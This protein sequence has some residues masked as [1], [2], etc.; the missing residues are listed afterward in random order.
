MS[1]GLDRKKLMDVL[2]IPEAKIASGGFGNI[3]KPIKVDPA[4]A[5]TIREAEA[6]AEGNW[7]GA[8]TIFYEPEQKLF[9]LTY[10]W[11][12]PTDRGYRAVIAR[13]ADGINFTDVWSRE[14]TDFATDATSLERATLIK[15]PITGNYQYWIC[16]DG[17]GGLTWRIYKLTD[18]TD[19]A[20]FDPTTITSVIP[21]GAAGEWDDYYV[22]DPKVFS[23]AG[24]LAMLYCG[25]NNTNA[26]GG[27][28]TSIDGVT[29]T[30]YANNPINPIGASGEWDD[31]CSVPIAML[32]RGGG[33]L[34]YYHARTRADPAFL[35]RTG[36]RAWVPPFVG[37][38][39]RLTPNAPFLEGINT[40]YPNFKY[41]DVG[42]VGGKMYVYYEHGQADGSFDLVVNVVELE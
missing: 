35:C 22:K 12:N 19:P 1:I 11:R 28:A 15:N 10:R 25:Y 42:V 16:I 39:T 3:L 34:I 23:L 6:D 8:P 17:V 27:I 20:N 9:W 26:Q 14:K 37:T 32:A 13:G 4:Q 38:P 29:W 40:A 2:G 18:V 31:Q 7:V 30:K 33:W 36:L 5:T 41:V 21:L 24:L